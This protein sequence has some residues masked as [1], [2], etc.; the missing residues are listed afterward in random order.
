M[1]LPTTIGMSTPWA[2][3]K[4][5]L[6]ATIHRSGTLSSSSSDWYLLFSGTCFSVVAAVVVAVSGA[7][8]NSEKTWRSCKDSS[9]TDSE[10][11][12]SRTFPS[13]VQL[14]QFRPWYWECN[15][16]QHD[17]RSDLDKDSSLQRADQAAMLYLPGVRSLGWAPMW[18]YFP[19]KLHSRQHPAKKIVPRLSIS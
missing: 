9:E 19:S 16:E 12:V 7:W 2:S 17:I 6:T 14:Y 13:K 8:E 3:V 11:Q 5:I 18:P 1:T 4:V 10:R 15:E